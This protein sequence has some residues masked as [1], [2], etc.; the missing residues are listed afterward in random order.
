MTVME[1]PKSK[2]PYW[3]HFREVA[4]WISGYTHMN[5]KLELMRDKIDVVCQSTWCKSLNVWDGKIHR[6][7]LGR[8]YKFK[9]EVDRLVFL[10]TYANGSNDRA[11]YTK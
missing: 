11:Y 7:E 5:V 1:R 2:W 8:L 3:V 10:M 4:V 9:D 6:V